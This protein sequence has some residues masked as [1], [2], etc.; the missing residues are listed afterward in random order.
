[1]FSVGKL[2]TFS[3]RPLN[4]DKPNKISLTI[5]SSSIK[6][7]KKITVPPQI[8]NFDH[9][10][11]Y[12]QMAR[13]IALSYGIVV[14]F[15]SEGGY[16]LRKARVELSNNGFLMKQMIKKRIW[17]MIYTDEQV[18]YLKKDEMDPKI[19]LI[20]TSQIPT[21]KVLEKYIENNHNCIL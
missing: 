8:I 20:W 19:N 6:E 14:N 2:S 21:N 5:K 12:P 3:T 9:F 13:L 16:K 11:V 18:K 7:F 10:E 4:E 15:T 17:W 1:M